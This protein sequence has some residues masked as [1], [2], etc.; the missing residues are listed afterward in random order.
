MIA[1][2]DPVD[3]GD[4]VEIVVTVRVVTGDVTLVKAKRAV[5]LENLLPRS[6]VD[7]AEVVAH[8]LPRGLI[9]R[10]VHHYLFG[11]VDGSVPARVREIAGGALVEGGR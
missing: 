9:G 3:G 6:V 5:H 4:L 1:S 8:H 11:G 2:V 10:A 7:S